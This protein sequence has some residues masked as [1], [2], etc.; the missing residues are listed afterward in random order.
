M[1]LGSLPLERHGEYFPVHCERS[2]QLRCAR[3]FID[4]LG[5]G[6]SSRGGRGVF[7]EPCGPIR[8]PAQ[9]EEGGEGYLRGGV[10]F[11]RGGGVFLGR[12]DG[13]S[14]GRHAR[15]I[16]APAEGQPTR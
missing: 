8:P 15:S 13:R 3:P 11:R 1:L 6:G 4:R 7:D 14:R 16:A 10:F 5:M 2:S 12:G 9:K